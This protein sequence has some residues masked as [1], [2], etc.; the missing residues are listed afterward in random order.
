MV[1]F[2][3]HENLQRNHGFKTATNLS[4][5]LSVSLILS[6]LTI[7][8]YSQ[9]KSSWITLLIS[10]TFC[11]LTTIFT[12]YLFT[13]I[14]WAWTRFGIILAKITTPVVLGFFYILVLTPTALF[15]RLFSKNAFNHS[16]EGYDSNWVKRTSQHNIKNQF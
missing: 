7:Y 5:G 16:G 8:A 14:N 1:N 4:F 13:P 6:A 9:G 11:F 2:R 3:N 15:F 12:P 10:S